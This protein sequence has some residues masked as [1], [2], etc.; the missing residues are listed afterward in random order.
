MDHFKRIYS[1]H[2]ATYYQLI[3][4][5]DPD[6]NLPASLKRITSFAGKRWLD[7]ATGTGRLPL[8]LAGA[9]A[10]AVG[11]DLHA[12]ML[13][14][15]RVQRARV[16]GVWT[17]AQ[18]DMCRVPLVSGWADIVTVGWAIGHF[19]RWYADDW[20]IPAGRVLRELHRLAAPNGVI[21]IIETVGTGTLTPGPPNLRLA[22]YYTWLE[23][24]WGFAGQVVSCDLSFSSVD[25][26]AAL[27]GF[28]FGTD[29]ADRVRANHWARLQG[30][31]GLW[32]KRV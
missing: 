12:D 27:T 17:L 2:A 7:L 21:V 23:Q 13:R 28:F 22:A 10:R 3:A 15:S 30:W 32:S 16:R 24:E 25:E 19:T 18:G 11:V 6:G 14:Q 31:A 8:Q 5:E 29:M 1:Y 4:R 20:P 9:T 26:A